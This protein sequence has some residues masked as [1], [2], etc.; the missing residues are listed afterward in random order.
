MSGANMRVSTLYGVL[1]LAL[2]GCA[3]TRDVPPS[4]PPPT[5]GL[6]SPL[7]M[8]CAPFARALSGLQLRGDA[9]D[10]WWQAEGRYA[11]GQTPRV[12]AVLVFA[13]S[14]RLGSGHVAVVSAVQSEREILVTHANWLR[15][16]LSEDAPVVDVSAANDWS[17]VRVWWPPTGGLGVT[18]F[19][20][21]G[22]IE[23][24]RPLTRDTIVWTTRQMLAA[25][26]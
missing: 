20:T 5:V 16:A 24:E 21:L 3:A 18:E 25:G 1:I 19:P 4:A 26:S 14:A 6:A 7:V 22:F 10:W 9:A 23:P 2:A 8:E 13:R 11:R 17:R 12:G 15:G